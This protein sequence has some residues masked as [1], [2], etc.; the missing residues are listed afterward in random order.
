MVEWFKQDALVYKFERNGSD[1]SKERSDQNQL[2]VSTLHISTGNASLILKRSGFKDRGAYRCHV[3]T[4]GGVLI[5]SVWVAAPIR[6]LFLELSRLSGYEELK[7]SVRDVYPAPRVTWDTEPPTY[8][9]LRPVTRMHADRTGLFT[10]DSRLKRLKGNPAL[11]YIC[12]VSAPYGGPMWTAS[13]KVREIRGAEG[14]DLTLPC[15]APSYMDNA[16]L[17]W[18]F[19]SGEETSTILSYDSRSKHISSPPPWDSYVELDAYKVTFGEGSLRLMDPKPLEHSGSYTCEFSLQ[20]SK[21]TEHN[22]VTIGDP[23][24]EMDEPMT[25]TER[26]LFESYKSCTGP[27]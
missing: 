19:S 13:L 16:A 1:G 7:C 6:G 23:S 11:N 20:H 14:K 8:E 17:H 24:G 27:D 18:T 9:A 12:K 15:S 5:A 22:D 21:H 4:S 3:Q 25:R 2:S 10:V 26:V